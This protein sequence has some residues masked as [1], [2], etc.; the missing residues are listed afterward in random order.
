MRKLACLACVGA[1]A[2]LPA[3]PAQAAPAEPAAH[4]AKRCGTIANG[5]YRVRARV[6]RCTFA[7]RWSRAYLRSGSRPRG[8]ACSRPGS[9]I[10]LYCR[11]GDRSFWAERR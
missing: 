10:A 8:Y 11:K 2:A 7:R 6:A 9:G 1:L 3:A 5:K 4:A